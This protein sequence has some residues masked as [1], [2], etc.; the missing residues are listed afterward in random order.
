MIRPIPET[1]FMNPLKSFGP[2]TAT[3]NGTVNRVLRILSCFAEKERWGLNELSR[4]L[5]LP[6]GSTHRLLSLCK[7]LG[8]ITQDEEGHYVPGME[9][10]RLAGKLASEMPINR[11]AEP[12]LQSVRDKTNETA[13]LTLLARNDLKMYFSL[14][15]SPAHPMRYTIEKNRLQPLSWGATGRTLL[16]F[17]TP[18]EIDEVIRRAEPSPLD[19]RPLD[20]EELRRSLEAIRRDGYA[21]T[22]AQRAPDSYGMAVPFFDRR[23]EVRGNITLTIPD[24]RFEAHDRQQ[25]VALLREAVAALSRQLGWA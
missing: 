25:L 22:Y 5:H 13:I 17:L 15:A 10:Y 6:R 23:G 14:T 8:Y 16:A 11:I 7:P 3:D 9:L 24:F 21:I 2:A 12:I 1:L 4:A 18:E 20:P 19:G